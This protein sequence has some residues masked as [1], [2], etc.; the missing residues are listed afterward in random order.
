MATV[1][2]NKM[3]SA[4]CGENTK[5]RVRMVGDVLE[6][7]P[8]NRVEG[9][10]LPKGEVLVELREKKQAVPAKRFTLPKGMELQVSR[11]YR[12]EVRPRGWIA[13]IPM[14]AE[15]REIALIPGGGAKPA[16]ASVTEK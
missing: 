5:V 13:M 14:T 3:A 9:K 4:L 2:L 12:A 8:T 15:E 7:R 6:L 16:G 11:M 1:N 10:N